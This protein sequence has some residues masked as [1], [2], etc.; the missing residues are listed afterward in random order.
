MFMI[1]SQVRHTLTLWRDGF[2]VDDGELRSGESE[3]DKA[4][5]QSVSKG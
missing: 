3:A 5:M 4:F 2:S 1:T